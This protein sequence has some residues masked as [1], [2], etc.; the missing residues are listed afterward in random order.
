M[1]Y[2]K[3]LVNEMHEGPGWRELRLYRSAQ[4][5]IVAFQDY[6]AVIGQS[7]LMCSQ[8]RPASMSAF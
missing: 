1:E 3:G 7:H 6:T 4:R 8:N 5:S 2:D